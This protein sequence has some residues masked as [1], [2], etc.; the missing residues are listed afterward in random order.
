MA[1]I[2]HKIILPIGTVQEIGENGVLSKL[3]E[4]TFSI[5]SPNFLQ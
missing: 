1:A 2:V 4:R 5:D 3:D